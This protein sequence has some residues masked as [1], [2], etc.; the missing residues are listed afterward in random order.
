MSAAEPGNVGASEGMPGRLATGAESPTAAS[1]STLGRA[2]ALTVLAREMY[3]AGDPV[4]RRARDTGSIR[5][6]LQSFAHRLRVEGRE[7][8]PSS[9]AGLDRSPRLR[10]RAKRGLW[11]LG[12][13]ATFRYDRLLAELAELNGQLAERLAD[14][15]RELE[16]ERSDR[17]NDAGGR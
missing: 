15:E 17:R 7:L 11:R 16:R 3:W 6:Q 8:Y 5:E 4:K 13:F 1:E 9:E 10:R 2:D 12:R 14:V